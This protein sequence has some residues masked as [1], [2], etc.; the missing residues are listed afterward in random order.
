MANQQP[1]RFKTISEF[2]DF[3]DL[4]KPEH[5]LVSVYNF[6]DLKYL[7][8]EEPKSLML[9]SPQKLL[10]IWSA[11]EGSSPWLDKLQLY[12]ARANN[13]STCLDFHPK[14]C[15]IYSLTSNLLVW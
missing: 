4:P 14:F 7:N 9:D 3:R 15:V 6:E 13:K 2:H 8:S 12:F 1:L 10:C 5:P 11:W